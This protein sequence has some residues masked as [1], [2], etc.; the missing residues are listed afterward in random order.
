VLGPRFNA[1]GVARALAK[2]LPLP[3]LGNECDDTSGTAAKTQ[4]E[5]S[6]VG[7]ASVPSVDKTPN[8]TSPRDLELQKLVTGTSH[9]LHSTEV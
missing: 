7:G 5:G 8:I 1:A 6:S 9:I 3:N 4:G 2:L